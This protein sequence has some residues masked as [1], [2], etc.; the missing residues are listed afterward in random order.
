VYKGT[1]KIISL[2]AKFFEVIQ[3][4]VD[5]ET[6]L[7]DYDEIE[8]IAAQE[9]PKLII[10]G[11]T[12]YPREI[13]HKRLAQ[14]AASVR[15]YYLADIAH[16]A[17]LVAGDICQNPV[18]IADVVTMTTHKTLRGPRGAI[19]L[20]RGD[21]AQAIDRAV[22]PGIQGGPFNN[23]IAGIAVC[24]KEAMADSFKQYAA[25]MIKNAQALADRLIELEFDVL[26]GGT[27]KHL[28]VIDLRSKNLAVGIKEST[29]AGRYFARALDTAGITT[30]KN[31][32]PFE[33][34]SAVDPSGI[35]LGTPTVTTRGMKE[36]EM[37]QIAEWMN[38]V[39]EITR[40]YCELDFENFENK[41]KTDPEILAIRKEVAALC[42]KFPLE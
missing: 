3:Y 5:K 41:L 11:G 36:K 15:A 35:R 4:K 29:S 42:R 9:K 18:G 8:R 27:D 20:S 37:V 25:Q 10:S 39:M 13:D 12:A 14:I 21:L 17:G 7:F 26:T 31:T 16:E 30:N 19:I 38:K 1:N 33:T 28:L 34:G 40:K 22:F 23:N 2:V 6:K 32:V 24:L